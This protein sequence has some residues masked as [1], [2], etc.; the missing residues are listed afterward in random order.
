MRKYDIKAIPT[1]YKKITYRSRLEARWAVFFDTLKVKKHYEPQPFNTRLGGYLPDFYLSKTEWLVEV[2]PNE[3]T[4]EELVKVRDVSRQNF[5]I[6]IVSGEPN[7]TTVTRFFTN[8]VEVHYK[9]SYWQQISA[10]WKD[11]PA[12]V[13]V[14][15]LNLQ[16]LTGKRNFYKSFKAAKEY[17]FER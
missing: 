15:L 1:E 11:R 10:Y 8:G 6:A 12:Y 3:P 4:R 5:R 14:N 7:I 13:L 2:K 9:P 16:Q 17:N